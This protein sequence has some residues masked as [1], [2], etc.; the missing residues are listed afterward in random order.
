MRNDVPTLR[1]RKFRRQVNGPYYRRSMPTS[2]QSHS[3][4][5]LM[6]HVY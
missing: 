3:L 2:E 4:H 1:A 6:H 5:A